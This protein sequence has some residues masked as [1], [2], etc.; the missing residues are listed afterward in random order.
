[1]PNQN[2]KTIIVAG[3]PRSGTSI[4]TYILQRLGVDMG[5]HT[6][7]CDKCEIGTDQRGRQQLFGVT[8]REEVRQIENLAS[9]EI[10]EKIKEIVTEAPSGLWGFK[11][12]NLYRE[13]EDILNFFQDQRPPVVFII[14]YR[15]LVDIVRSA[16]RRGNPVHFNELME[17]RVNQYYKILLSNHPVEEKNVYHLSLEDAQADIRSHIEKLD[18]I[19]GTNASDKFK[20]QLAEELDYNQN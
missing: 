4:T 14:M 15:N 18:E 20:N 3:S 2:T 8:E 19:A 12:P 5:C 16:K 11:N 10:I 6:E 1:M 13:W 9:S 17:R 7:G